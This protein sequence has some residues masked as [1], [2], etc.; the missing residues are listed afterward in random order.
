MDDAGR[1]HWLGMTFVVGALYLAVNFGAVILAGTASS[2]R[3][4]FFWRWSAFIICGVMYVVHIA[5]EHF[6]VRSAPAPAA[7]HVSAAVALGALGLA[8]AANIHELGSAAGYRVRMLVALV[9]WP[10]LTAVPA[11]VVA[12]AVAAGLG[13]RWSQL[14]DS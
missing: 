10:L 9:A 8:L 1:Q 13:V 12:L 5:Y 7:W 3:M 14:E 2:S 11:F 4:L 6:R